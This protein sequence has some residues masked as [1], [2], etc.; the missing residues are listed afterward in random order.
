MNVI[1]F[2]YPA[3]LYADSVAAFDK[4]YQHST[5]TPV[6]LAL[7]AIVIVYLLYRCLAARRQ[8]KAAA[9]AA[10]AAA[11]KS[12]R[13]NKKKIAQPAPRAK[14]RLAASS[15]RQL[16]GATRVEARVAPKATSGSATAALS[17]TGPADVDV[18]GEHSEASGDG[19]VAATAGDV[20]R[21]VVVV[22]DVCS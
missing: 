5:I 18:S 22:R 10:A 20:A 14:S 19:L 11:A 16:A 4:L 8:R 2:V 12:K 9:I 21:F 1:N 3:L 17:S 15:E 13:S 7:L 6:V